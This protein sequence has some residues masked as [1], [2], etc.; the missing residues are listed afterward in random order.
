M[1][2]TVYV[3]EPSTDQIA[4]RA[5][6]DPARVVRFDTN[7]SPFSP[8]WAEAQAARG[9]RAGLNEYPPADYADLVEAVSGHAGVETDRIVVGAGADELIDLCAKAFLPPGGQAVTT[10]PTYSMYGVV[11]SQRR[12]R[13]AEL[14]RPGPEFRLAV[15]ATREAAASADLIWLCEP[16]NPTG[17]R[18]PDPEVAAVVQAA[19]GVVVLD[20]AYAEFAGDR[21]SPWVERHSNLVVVHTFSK[22]F[23][24]AGARV[25]YGLCP[26]E[27]ASGLNRV[28]PPGSVSVISAALAVRALTEQAW[29]EDS[30]AI[31]QEEK[32][33]LEAGLRSLGLH[34]LPSEANFLLVDF[35]ERADPVARELLHRGL[36]SRTFP[37]DSPLASHL[38]FTV[39]TPN[40]DRRLLEALDEVLG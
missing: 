11:T 19:G 32:T 12:A 30:V 4:R 17:Q 8:P 6:I 3:W 38:R 26:P 23:G 13:L 35:G 5:G 1:T 7:T 22:A 27:L 34:P 24:L 29:M 37:A 9:A 36:V 2:A 21:W 20:A 39:R 25:G 14:R 18:D 28:R 10:D 16:N 40:D 31:I 33:R 15:E